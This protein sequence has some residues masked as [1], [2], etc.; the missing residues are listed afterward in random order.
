MLMG[1]IL[2]FHFEALR[3][4]ERGEKGLV[5]RE[6]G[7]EGLL[8][9]ITRHRFLC[10]HV[11]II[12]SRLQ[13]THTHALTLTH[14]SRQKHAVAC[15]HMHKHALAAA[16]FRFVSFHLVFENETRIARALFAVSLK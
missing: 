7:V 12:V 9:S 1:S 8:L 2:R 15:T 4:V 11:C 13:H 5:G 14:T 10:M 3:G 16:F 6:R